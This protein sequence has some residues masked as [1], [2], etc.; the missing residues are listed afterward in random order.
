MMSSKLI[1]RFHPLESNYGPD[2]A[3]WFIVN[4]DASIIEVTRGLL[5]DIPK[6]L[7]DFL[8]L[9]LLPTTE[10]IMTEVT[11]PRMKMSQLRKMAPFAIED[12][13]STDLSDLHIAIAG[14]S[15]NNKLVV[16]GIK[17]DHLK[18]WLDKL[19]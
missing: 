7:D 8:I 18:N 14:F 10:L 16:T 11:M 12:Y 4:P 3:D 17:H 1:I 19:K 2:A 6:P 15:A 9:V 5:K 13:L